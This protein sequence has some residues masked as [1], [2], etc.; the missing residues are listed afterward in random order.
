M[1]QATDMLR[2]LGGNQLSASAKT[3]GA[4]GSIDFA[5][6]LEQARAGEIASGLPVRVAPGAGVELNSEQ[7]GRLSA[8]ADMAE[9]HG[10]A[11]AAFM[12]DGQVVA[13]DVA[14]RTVTGTITANETSVVQ[15]IDAIVTVA[16]KDAK[17]AAG[18]IE[19]P[20]AFGS[21]QPMN[22]SLLDALAR[23]A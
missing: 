7:L 8:A 15:G 22:V 18:V 3:L 11:R 16:A 23:R 20:S 21:H 6:L 1:T 5:Q 17:G 4:S 9:A 10:A 19:P 14:T 13:M 2:A 12:I